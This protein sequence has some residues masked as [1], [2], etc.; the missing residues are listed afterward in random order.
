MVRILALVLCSIS[1]FAPPSAFSAED[2]KQGINY[3]LVRPAQAT[4]VEAGKVEVLEVL[5]YGC[6]ACN[7][8]LP[9]MQKL[10]AALPPNAKINYLPAS[11]NPT[12]D[13]PMF[14]RAFFTAQ[15]LGVLDKTHE[16]M[17]D[18]VWKTGE[19]AVVDPA[20][21]RLK[22]P[23]PAIEDAARWYVS[24]A[25]VK[26]DEFLNTARSFSVEAK[27]KAADRQIIVSQVDR[28]PTIIVNGKYRLNAESAGGYD[29]LISLVKWLVAKE[30]GQ[31]S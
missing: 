14:Q 24:H 27:M 13:W 25:G 9:T 3:F 29:Q 6:P 20:T 26:R 4:S 30:S 21:N 31:G 18:A 15:A 11:F 5:S 10:A 2:W 19:L 28:T 16:A 23:L 7:S 17:F 12:E 8:F 22:N 1:L